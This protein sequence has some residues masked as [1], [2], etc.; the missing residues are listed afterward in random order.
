MNIQMDTDE[1]IPGAGAGGLCRSIR[2]VFI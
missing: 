1:S 2:S